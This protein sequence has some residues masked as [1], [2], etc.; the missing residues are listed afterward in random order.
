MTDDIT[1][2]PPPPLFCRPMIVLVFFKLLLHEST[3]CNAC[4]EDGRCLPAETLV[5]G[6]TLRFPAFQSQQHLMLTPHWTTK[7][8]RLFES[9]EEEEEEDPVTLCGRRQAAE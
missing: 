3:K 9:G 7:Q 4:L 6:M 8:P 5:L 2:T 1:L